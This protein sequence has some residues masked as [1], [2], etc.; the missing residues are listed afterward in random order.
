LLI[1]SGAL[2]FAL[3]AML[4]AGAGTGVSIFGHWHSPSRAVV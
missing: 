3:V 4:T 1:Y 2:H